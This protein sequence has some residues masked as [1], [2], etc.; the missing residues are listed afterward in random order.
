M[1]D[2][3][4]RILAGRLSRSADST[5]TDRSTARL[6]CVAGGVLFLLG[7]GDN[8]HPMQKSLRASEVDCPDCGSCPCE[9]LPRWVLRDRDGAK[10]M[11]HV[12][13]RCSHR[14]GTEAS[15]ECEPVNFLSEVTYPCVRIIDHEGRFINLQYYLKTGTLGGCMKDGGDDPQQPF[16]E[17][18]Y[19]KYVNPTCQGSPYRGAVPDYYFAPFFVRS[20]DLL[21]AQD[22]I[23]YLS[24]QDCQTNVDTYSIDTQSSNCVQLGKQTLCPLRPVPQ[25]VRELLPNP[26]Y[27]LSVEYQ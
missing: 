26:P 19:L 7:G 23:W 15:S 16:S 25:W 22:S 11:A 24:G 12:E 9:P 8:S 18:S 2:D 5:N 14:S 3:T 21:W 13:P 4:L 20:Q 27:S 6:W 10:V 17:V 1:I